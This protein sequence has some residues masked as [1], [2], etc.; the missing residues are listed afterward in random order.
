MSKVKPKGGRE[1]GVELVASLFPFPKYFHN[2]PQPL[3]HGH[4]YE[5]D[6]DIAEG[7]FRHIKKIF[8]QLE[9]R[10]CVRV[11]VSV[12]ACMRVCLSEEDMD[13]AEGCCRHIKKIS[14]QLEL[15]EWALRLR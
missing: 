15:K 6:M 2:A 13:I 3:F 5:E 9:V 11:C 10:M 8:T 1:V 14:T 4:S 7:C 12:Y